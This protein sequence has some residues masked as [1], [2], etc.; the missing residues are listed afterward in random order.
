MTRSEDRTRAQGA[1][2]VFYAVD[3]DE[4][5]QW[6]GCRDQERFDQAWAVIRE[7][8]DAGWEPEE[9]EVMERLLRRLVFDGF[10]Y[11]G[12]STDERYYLTQLLIDLFDEYVD[13]EAMSEDMPL[14]QLVEAVQ[15]LPKTGDARELAEW[16]V[17]GREFGG[18]RPVWETGRVED[19]LSYF[20]YVTREEAPRLAAA[21]AEAQL[22]ARGR[23]SLLLKQ[24]RSAAEECARAGLD[25][26]S[27][28]G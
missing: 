3:L 4:L 24:V 18:S 22:R 2:V 6:I 15:V 11:D 9:L 21:L 14:D 12:I 10:L 5:R 26:L 7:D 20:G 23:P 13:Q 17:R 27:F 1:S 16:L 8:E 25:L 19:V 28:V